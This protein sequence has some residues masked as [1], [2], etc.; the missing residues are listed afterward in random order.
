[1]SVEQALL[2]EAIDTAHAL[3]D[4]EAPVRGGPWANSNIRERSQAEA[5][6]VRRLVAMA[7][8]REDAR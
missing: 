6:H 4:G 1:M 2:Q 7:D 5:A 3:I 8:S